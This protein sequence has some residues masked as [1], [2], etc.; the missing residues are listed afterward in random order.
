MSDY[1]SIPFESQNAID[2]VLNLDDNSKNAIGRLWTL[3]MVANNNS[4]LIADQQLE[5][6][7]NSL[8]QYIGQPQTMLQVINQE[9]DEVN[10]RIV[11]EDNNNFFNGGLKRRK[12]GKTGKKRKRGAMKTS[13]KKRKRRN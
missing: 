6:F 3:Y 2:T 13:R 5:N 7:L 4:M 10:L 11:H 1:D 12:K 8:Q 9:I